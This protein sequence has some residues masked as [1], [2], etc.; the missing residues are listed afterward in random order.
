MPLAA[1]PAIRARL[2]NVTFGLL[3]SGMMSFI[4][5]GIATL[6]A[7]GFAVVFAAP[8]DFIGG[9]MGAW[10][11]SWAIAFPTVLV[12]APLVRKIVAR[13]FGSA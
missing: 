10:V 6:R 13:L 11:I 4:V 5:S 2:I 1:S 3:L 7:L 8:G 9:W 12:V